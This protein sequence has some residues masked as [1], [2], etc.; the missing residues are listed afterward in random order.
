M[1]ELIEDLHAPCAQAGTGPVSIGM[2]VSRIDGRAKVTGSARYAAEHPA[3]GLAFGVVVNS[4]IAKGRIVAIDDRRAKAV[5][6]VIDVITHL[7]RPKVRRY[8]PSY[9]DMTAPGGSPFKPLLDADVVYSGQPVALVVAET[10]EAAR[11][12]ASLVV[13]EYNREMHATNLM[14][15]LDRAHKPSR[16]KA[17]FKPPPD[18][19]GDAE[20]AFEAAS[21]KVEAEFWSGVEYHNPLELFATTVICGD[22]GHLTIYDKTQSSQNSRWYVS[23]VFGIPKRKVTAARP[24][25]PWCGALVKRCARRPTP[26]IASAGS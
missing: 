14:D 16:L 24:P 22:D 6:G 2:P 21:V 9:K 17:G 3:E 5:A 13:V 23:H 19:K 11:Y 25:A 12:A 8:G 26:T 18:E 7:K 20:A 10:F 4:T 15:N 1:T